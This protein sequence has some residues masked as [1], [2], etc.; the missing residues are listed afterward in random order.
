M[1]AIVEY[2]PYRKVDGTA[3]R[4]SQRQPYLAGFG[5]AAVRVDMRGTGESDGVLTDEYSQQEQDDALEIL[6]WIREQP[7]CDGNLGVWGISW[8]GFNALQ[9]AALRPPGLGA[10]MTMCS[11]DDRYADDVHYRGGCVLGLDMLHWASSML[12][13]ERAAARPAAVRRRVARGLARAAGDPDPVDRAL[14]RPPAARRLLAARL[15]LRGLRGDRVPGL[16]GRRLRRRLHERG[17]ATARRALGPAQGDHR[18]VGALV[19]RGRPAGAV[20]RL[21]PGDRALV[22]PLAEGRR[23]RRHGRA[24][25]PRLD[26]GLGGAAADVRRPGGPLG[27]RGGVAV[28]AHRDAGVGAAG[29]GATRAA[30]RPVVRDGGRRVVRGGP[31]RRPRRRPAPRRRRSRSS[32]TRS[33]SRSR[34]RSSA[35]PRRCWS[36]P[37]TGPTRSSP[38]ASAT[39]S[40]TGPRRS[41]RAASST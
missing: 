29:R 13:L 14:A 5:Y 23:E 9:I 30:R 16:R 37:P 26:A 33:R 32:S 11:T 31:V 12:D 24:D 41:S 7:W 21:P 17:A 34:W 38:Y 15:G 40:R 3:M 4:D 22:R 10:I 8:G 18:A 25:A 19:P 39:S 36:W 27:R 1:P 6:A 20:D 2:L 35:S 28:A